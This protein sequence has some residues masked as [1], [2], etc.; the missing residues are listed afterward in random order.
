MSSNRSQNP[1]GLKQI[2]LDQIWDDLRAGIQQVYTRQSMAKSRYMELYT[3]VYNYCTSVHQSNQA[4]GPGVPPPKPSKKA[5]TPGGAQFVG[6]ELYKRLK[7]FLKNYLTNLLKDG[8]DLMD[9][10]VLKFYTQQWEDY[11][12]SSKVLNGICAYLN[13]HWVRRECD[14]GRKGIY[15]IYSLALVTW[16]ECLFRPLNKQVTNAVLKLID[17]ERNG[18]TINTRLIS[19]VVQSYVELGLNEDDAF[20]KGPTLS[21][22][23]E[24][25][26]SQFL[27]DTERF[28]TRES[29]EFLQQNPVTEYMK[30]AEARLL[31]EQRRVQVYLHESTQDELARKCEQVL[32]EKHLEIFHTEFQNLLD[33]DKNEDLGRMY[34]LVSRITDGLGE[35]KKLLETHIYNQGL[36]AIE[37]CGEA[38][39]NDPKMYVQTILDVH[40]KYN[41]L[42]M[43]AFNN[44]AGFVAALDKVFCSS[45]LLHLV[46]SACGRFINNNA[47]TKMVQSSSKSPELL[48]RYC[49]SLL[50][51]S[52]KNPEEAELEDTLNQ[53]MVVF[54]YI[55]D[56]D[57]FQKFYAK[58]LAKR[59]VHQNSA[60]DDAEASMISKLKQACGFEYTSK[61][62]RMFQDIGVSKDLNE[63][64]KKHLTNSEPLDL[65]FSIQ[66]LS[67]GSWPFQQ[68]CTFALPSEL[69]RSYQRFTAFYASRHSG[70]KL[71]WL[72][73]LSK[74]ELVTNCFKNRYTLQAST[75]QMA[76][77][78]QYN[79]EDSYTVQQL[80]DSTQIK[81]DILVQ[82]LQILLKS[83]LLVLE[84]E[85]AN[86]DEVGVQT[87]QLKKLRVKHQCAMKTEQK[88][89]QET[90]HKNIEEDRKLLI[91]AAIV[92]IMKM[93][94]MLKH[95]QL[96][97]E[98]L[99]Q[100][101]SRFKP[102]VPVIKKCIDIL[103]EKEYLERV[104]GEKD[105]YSYLA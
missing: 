89:E 7:E 41:A 46:V 3:H 9:E 62:Q 26:E 51:K 16:R 5:P 79:T 15:E 59:L 27:A 45:A 94:K 80:T 98:V 55:E 20:A 57:V 48:A 2:G 21:V 84:D 65:D 25:F 19:G 90:T 95:Q 77:L 56:K 11:R 47:V 52:S 74:G 33:A 35:L 76:I 40:K 86:V 53:V 78:L 61:L 14:E 37:K 31:E 73:H 23:K 82:V 1:H 49:D 24:Y 87:G 102:R 104:D 39:L 10:S 99:N 96:L 85:N 22:Y 17:K 101:S 36:A 12:F 43:S 105:T 50:K 4:R 30:K 38:A 67:S 83:K 42:V 44:D 103:I 75:F 8:E 6:L 60:S 70:R 100:L 93:R 32:I 88:Q 34:N 28:Y 64:F 81:I 68:S 91:Q 92:R 71:T 72:Y 97:A 13:R 66:V 58:M 18:E 29:T 54:K 69:E 63:Q